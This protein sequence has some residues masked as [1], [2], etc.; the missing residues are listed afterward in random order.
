MVST[1][2]VIFVAI[3]ML[4]LAFGSG[5]LAFESGGEQFGYTTLDIGNSLG[6]IYGPCACPPT[7]SNIDGWF[8]HVMGPL[9]V[10]P[11]ALL[12]A[13]I[14]LPVG[15]LLAALSLFHWKLTIWAGAMSILSGMSW[16]E[17][18]NI[19]QPQVVRG[20]NAW[21]GY[22]GG[23]ISSTVWAQAGPYIAVAGGVI[24]L[25]GYALSK[26]EKLEVPID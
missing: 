1:R 17:G 25:A 19:V 26:M 9:L 22:H 3:F 12:F 6:S 14:S 10:A 5:W 2:V 7:N 8:W 24:L 13:I 15:F 4:F 21:F 20:L 23:T 16:L 11:G 18:L